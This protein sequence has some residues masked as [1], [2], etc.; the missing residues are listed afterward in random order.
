MLGPELL[1]SI[2]LF[3][4][5]RKQPRNGDF[6]LRTSMGLGATLMKRVEDWRS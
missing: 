6:P 1:I 3:M 2:D 4:I 5:R